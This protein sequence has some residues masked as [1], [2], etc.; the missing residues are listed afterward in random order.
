MSQVKGEMADLAWFL[1]RADF[2]Q[3]LNL[4][5]MISFK[6]KILKN[7]IASALWGGK[8]LPKDVQQIICDLCS[9]FITL[10]PVLAPGKHSAKMVCY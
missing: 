4:G 2:Q 5:N 8:K 3:C 6:K 10:Y 9:I 7:Y 1:G